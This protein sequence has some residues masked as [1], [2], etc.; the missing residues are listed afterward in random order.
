MKKINHI[1]NVSTGDLILLVNKGTIKG[2]DKIES[3]DYQNGKYS[4]LTRKG[5]THQGS[6]KNY[7]EDFTEAYIVDENVLNY[8][9]E[10][11]NSCIL[12]IEYVFENLYGDVV[13]SAFR[14]HLIEASLKKFK[15]RMKFI[16][17]VKKYNDTNEPIHIVRWEVDEE[18]GYTQE[19]VDDSQK[20]LKEA[21]E[22]ELKDL[23]WV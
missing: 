10:V 17:F 18:L 6:L 22:A 7:L 19:M 5:K 8:D 11:F 16:D 9:D 12:D 15:A 2:I 14:T 20:I 21:I 4:Y 23:N 1:N 13:G 3:I